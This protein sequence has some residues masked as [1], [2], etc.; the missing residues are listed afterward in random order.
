MFPLAPGGERAIYH[1]P[2][3]FSVTWLWGGGVELPYPLQWLR[4]GL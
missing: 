1:P 3:A 4:M 2:Q